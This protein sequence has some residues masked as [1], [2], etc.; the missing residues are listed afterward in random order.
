MFK[1]L[2][3]YRLPRPWS[4]DKAAFEEALQRA[5]A[6]ECGPLEPETR[7]WLPRDGEFV[8]S[9]DGKYMIRMSVSRRL[10]PAK[11]IKRE[12]AKVAAEIERQQGYKP[13]R[14]QMKE[15]LERV[16]DELLPKAMVDTSV[17][18]AWF[19][20]KDGFFF[21]EASSVATADAV[22]ELLRL[23]LDEFP[24]GA[25]QTE[26]S[27]ANFMTDLLLSGSEEGFYAE[28]ACELRGVSEEKDTVS[29]TRHALDIDEIK[30]HLSSG[31]LPTRLAITWD[32]RLS[33]VLTE[34][35]LVKKITILDLLKDQSEESQE[36]EQFDADFALFTGE[37]LRMFASLIQ[38]MGGEVE[39]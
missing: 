19:S 29:Y 4:F 25:L 23:S 37:Y 31:K 9:N 16:R 7:G 18:N 6:R 35:M 13:G 11:I 32:D 2:I 3:A 28:R 33:F 20:P 22:I 27:S 26:R 12:A 15:I 36:E 38:V 10:L 5:P 8:Y 24:L 14:K 39:Q 30:A 17:T 1:N 21:I 34:R